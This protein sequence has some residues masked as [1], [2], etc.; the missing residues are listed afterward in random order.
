MMNKN[1]IKYLIDSESHTLKSDYRQSDLQCVYTLRDTTFSKIRES[2]ALTGAMNQ[3]NK[4]SSDGTTTPSRSIL[5][6]EM[7]LRVHKHRKQNSRTDN[8]P[9][10]IS[11][12]LTSTSI[13]KS[14]FIEMN[15]L[16]NQLVCVLPM[17]A[18]KCLH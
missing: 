9:Q 11:S 2:H 4:D 18:S 16:Q 10:M 15:N 5:P 6:R 12:V 7:F 13:P 3:I 8:P 17:L 1:T 14:V